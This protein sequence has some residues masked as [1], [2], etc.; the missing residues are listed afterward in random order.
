MATISEGLDVFF[1]QLLASTCFLIASCIFCYFL[2]QKI[3]E[4]DDNNKE[5]DDDKDNDD[6]DVCIV[7]FCSTK[8]Y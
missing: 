3:T 8:N 2:A 6:D 1:P 5:N 7:L 4:N